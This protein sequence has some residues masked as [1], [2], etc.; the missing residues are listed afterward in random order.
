MLTSV[1]GK[2][3]LSRI[4]RQQ[5]LGPLAGQLFSEVGASSVKMRLR[6]TRP[7]WL[8]FDVCGIVR[9]RHVRTT[10][11]VNGMSDNVIGCRQS[12]T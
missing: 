4:R 8:R 6:H 2:F 11:T 9:Q 3:D 12:H 7:Y 1:G 5:R 10:D